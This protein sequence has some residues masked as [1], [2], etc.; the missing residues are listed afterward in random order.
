MLLNGAKETVKDNH[1]AT[2]ILN[3]P[4]GFQ[5]GII[6]GRKLIFCKSGALR[7]TFNRCKGAK[8]EIGGL[9]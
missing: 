7:G 4:S 5:K 8:N 3:K 1:I 6:H 2:L 9:R